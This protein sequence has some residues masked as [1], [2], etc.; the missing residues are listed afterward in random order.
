MRFGSSNKSR[1]QTVRGNPGKRRRIYSTDS[2]VYTYIIYNCLLQDNI[3]R[4]Q[5]RCN[6]LHVHDIMQVFLNVRPERCRVTKPF[7]DPRRLSGIFLETA[8]SR[9]ETSTIPIPSIDGHTR[10]LRSGRGK[11]GPRGFARAL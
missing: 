9:F 8:T 7:L 5:T 2:N 3:P 11:R 6:R 4:K 1:G 10:V